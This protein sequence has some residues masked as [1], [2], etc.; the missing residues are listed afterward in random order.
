LLLRNGITD[1]ITNELV[2][3]IKVKI[4]LCIALLNS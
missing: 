3:S 2:R 4:D 1:N